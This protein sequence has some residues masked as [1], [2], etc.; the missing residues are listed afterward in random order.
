MSENPRQR[1]PE[2]GGPRGLKAINPMV[3]L[4]DTKNELEEVM[5][6]ASLVEDHESVA[7]CHKLLGRLRQATMNY[8][9][10]LEQIY[11]ETIAIYGSR[12]GAYA[13][14]WT[15]RVNEWSQQDINAPRTGS[16]FS[17]PTEKRTE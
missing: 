15:R 14:M 10:I 8:N 17:L 11:D 7:R 5:A 6:H 12:P 9:V 1:M 13:E 2:I 4:Y 3:R 16:V